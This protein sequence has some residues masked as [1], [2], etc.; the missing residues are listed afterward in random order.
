MLDIKI[1]LPE[2]ALSQRQQQ[3]QIMVRHDVTTY[4]SMTSGST[5]LFDLEGFL[6]PVED[7]LLFDR[8]NDATCTF[9]LALCL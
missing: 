4:S 2:L 8:A 7:L 9:A 5:S 1:K 6:R 3:L